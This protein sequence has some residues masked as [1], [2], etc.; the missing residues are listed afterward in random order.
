MRKLQLVTDEFG[1]AAVITNQVMAKVDGGA[2]MFMSDP[3]TP[4]GG[5]I[6]AHASTT[7]L[8]F[9]KSKGD[10][11]ICKIYDSP[12]LPEASAVFKI[13]KGGIEDAD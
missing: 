13:G 7:R 10:T 12:H 2:A 5:H 8:Y 6:L 9:K 11:R 3:K 4:I 1:V